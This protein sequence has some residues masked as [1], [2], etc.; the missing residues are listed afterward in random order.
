MAAG[1]SQR[2]VADD[3]VCERKIALRNLPLP[4]RGDEAEHDLRRESGGGYAH[5][6]LVKRCALQP[7][8]LSVGFGASNA[9]VPAAAKS[10]EVMSAASLWALYQRPV[11]PPP[12][13]ARGQQCD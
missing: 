9:N 6:R 7:N 5:E 1:G 10:T 8:L 13:A 11:S 2:R 3:L 4:R 12:P